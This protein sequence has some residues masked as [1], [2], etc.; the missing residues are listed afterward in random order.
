MKYHL[1]EKMSGRS[2]IEEDLRKATSRKDKA[3]HVQFKDRIE[4]FNQATYQELID[5]RTIAELKGVPLYEF[6]IKL[7]GRRVARIVFSLKDD[8]AHMLHLFIKKSSSGIKTDRKHID[9][10]LDRLKNS[11]C[12]DQ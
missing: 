3:V 2:F 6:R 1:C 7:V 9:I 4:R 5:S 10:A 11:N 8:V 12:T